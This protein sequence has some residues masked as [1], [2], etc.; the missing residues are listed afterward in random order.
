MVI[1]RMKNIVETAI[2]AE[3]FTTLV[4]AVKAADL[5]V[6][7][8]G[9]GPFTVFAPTDA[10]FSK[11]PSGVLESVLKDKKELTKILKYHVASGKRVE[12]D[13]INTDGERPVA[14]GRSSSSLS[15]RR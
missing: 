13:E 9:P 11:M 15:Q 4:R 1:E 8:S 3:N 7:L 10:A 6:A 2:A 12:N 5:V 14:H